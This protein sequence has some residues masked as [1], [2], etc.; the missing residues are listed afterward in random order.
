MHTLARIYNSN[1]IGA[2]LQSWTDLGH[3]YGTLIAQ[4]SMNNIDNFQK[5]REAIK[6][7]CRIALSFLVKRDFTDEV[8]GFENSAF[9]LYL[10]RFYA[11]DLRLSLHTKLLN[12]RTVQSIDTRPLI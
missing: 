12:L 9:Q 8:L 6:T 4:G 10:L 3:S 11:H 1:V 7:N 2:I 5:T